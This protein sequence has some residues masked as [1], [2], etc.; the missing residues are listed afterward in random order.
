MMWLCGCAVQLQSVRPQTNAASSTSPPF[1][2]EAGRQVAGISLRWEALGEGRLLL[3]VGGI[4]CV[5]G[6]VVGGGVVGGRGVAL[7]ILCVNIRRGLRVGRQGDIIYT[8]A[9]TTQCEVG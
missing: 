4:R 9:I 3:H 5:S 7:R 1:V 2:S 6:G 8:V